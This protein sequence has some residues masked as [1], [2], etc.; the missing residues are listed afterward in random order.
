MRHLNYNHLLYFWTVGREGT[1]ARAAEL[2]HVTPQT[3]SGQLK[4]LEEAVGAPL[5]QRR[6][7]HLQLTET[8]RTVFGYADEMF[9][10]GSELADVL[11]GRTPSGQRVFTVGVAD[12]VPKLVAYRMLEP[13]LALPEPMRMVCHEGKLEQLLADLS[14]HRLDLVLADSPVSPSLNLRVFNHALGET[15]VSFFAQR[16]TALRLRRRFPRSLS[17]Q[18]ML[19]PAGSTAL[20][21]GIDL[22]FHQ[23]GIDPW[24]VAEFDDSALMR[25]FGQ[26]GRGVFPVPTAIEQEVLL[27]HGVDL[28][29]RAPSVR[30]RFYAISAERRIRHPAVVAISDGAR[31]LFAEPPAQP[32]SEP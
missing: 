27:Q 26:S 23:Q 28:V 16:D 3:I 24:L 1:I 12:V 8:G 17:G 22:W 14:V 25:A 13:A 19:L 15:G 7:R 11:R 29:G 9:R 2:M 18:P 21:R 10:L 4:L 5:F 20:R 31:Q 32:L 6:G 30:E